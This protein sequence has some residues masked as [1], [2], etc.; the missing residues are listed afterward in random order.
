MNYHYNTSKEEEIVIENNNTYDIISVKCNQ[1]M[2]S[3]KIKNCSNVEIIDFHNS[4]GLKVVIVNCPNLKCLNNYYSGKIQSN[5]LYL[6][7]GCPSLVSIKLKG[8]KRVCIVNT[9]LPNLECINFSYIKNLSFNIKNNPK[10]IDIKIKSCKLG[11]IISDCDN[12]YSFIV[13]NCITKKIHIKGNN[14]R[15]WVLSIIKPTF[16]PIIDKPANNLETL[17]LVSRLDTDIISVPI[18]SVH[19]YIQIYLSKD[20]LYET[21]LRKFIMDNRRKI[22]LYN[23]EDTTRL[24]LEDLKFLP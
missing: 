12:M 11:N 20:N 24:D 5:S 23:Y 15:L 1:N 13:D 14:S 7:K 16:K 18:Q 21:S 4:P 2:K 10:L 3:L 6:G 9:K 17:K 8:F 19:R 22:T